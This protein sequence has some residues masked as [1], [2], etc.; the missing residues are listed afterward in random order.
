MS[1][2]P[3]WHFC[4]KHQFFDIDLKTFPFAMTVKMSVRWF[5]DEQ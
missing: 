3:P 5:L 1:N 4:G 2:N